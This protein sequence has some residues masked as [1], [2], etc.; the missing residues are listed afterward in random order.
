[1]REDRVEAITDDYI[2]LCESHGQGSP[3]RNKNS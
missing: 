3:Y 1:M 2:Q